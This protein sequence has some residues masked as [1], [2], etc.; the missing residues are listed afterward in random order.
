MTAVPFIDPPPA[1]VFGYSA[2]VISKWLR[3]TWNRGEFE[4]LDPAGRDELYATLKAIEYA[5]DAWQRRRVSAVTSG[6]GN[7]ETSNAEPSASSSRDMSSDQVAAMLGLTSRRARQLAAAGLGHKV[8]AVWVCD[9]DAVLA[10]AERRAA[11]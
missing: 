7:T 11:A 10:E 1:F 9:R 4:H 6:V 5:A 2:Q 8:G 3:S